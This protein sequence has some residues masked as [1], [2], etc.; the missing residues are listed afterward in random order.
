M[1]QFQ[2]HKRRGFT[3]VELLV[4]I[5]PPGQARMV[6]NPPFL[7]SRPIFWTGSNARIRFR[8]LL[9]QRGPT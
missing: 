1:N 8:R 6:A 3:L 4:V 5:A 2:R 7:K 9:R